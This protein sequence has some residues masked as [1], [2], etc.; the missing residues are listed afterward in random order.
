MLALRVRVRAHE[1]NAKVPIGGAA[2]PPRCGGDRVANS[3]RVIEIGVAIIIPLIR[4]SDLDAVSFRLAP[5]DSE[6]DSR[7]SRSDF[8]TF[9][10]G[11]PRVPV[12]R[13]GR[14]AVYFTFNLCSIRLCISSDGASG[15]VLLYPV[16]APWKRGGADREP[17]GRSFSI[18]VPLI[19]DTVQL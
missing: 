6:N 9:S 10:R 15:R 8:V 5:R 14:R 2:R 16:S 13:G 12:R 1:S 3:N 4:V 19:R 11:F 7:K 18:G 17:A